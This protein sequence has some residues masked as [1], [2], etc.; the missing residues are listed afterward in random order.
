MATLV[1]AETVRLSNLYNKSIYTKYVLLHTFL[2]IV[3]VVRERA[4]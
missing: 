2:F 4:T 3:Q 1:H